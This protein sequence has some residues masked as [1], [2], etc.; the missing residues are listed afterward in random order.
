MASKLGKAAAVLWLYQAWSILASRPRWSPMLHVASVVQPRLARGVSGP[1]R[2]SL[3]S[4]VLPTSTKLGTNPCQLQRWCRRCLIAAAV[5]RAS[6][7][8]S[9]WTW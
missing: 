5:H 9:S 4:A 7:G 8:E 1:V 6:G 3:T 2:R